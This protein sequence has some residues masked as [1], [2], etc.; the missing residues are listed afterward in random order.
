MLSEIQHGICR[1]NTGNLYLQFQFR[2][3][4]QSFGLYSDPT[5]NTWPILYCFPSGWRENALKLNQRK[6][7]KFTSSFGP[8]LQGDRDGQGHW[9]LLVRAQPLD[10]PKST[11]SP[12][13]VLQR[14]ASSWDYDL[15][16]TVQSHS[17]PAVI[18]PCIC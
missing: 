16:L 2:A 10:N 14:D 7:T 15:C 8:S 11:A 5:L 17:L 12:D 6:A 3:A 18:T 9:H 1:P 13:M 4:I